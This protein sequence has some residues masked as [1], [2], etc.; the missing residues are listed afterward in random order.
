[1]PAYSG[2]FQ[3]SGESGQPLSQGPCQVR[4]E[5]ESC[6]VTPAGGI[7]VA[8][9]LGDIDS[10]ARSDWDL[11]LKLYTGKTV[12]LRQFGPAFGRMADELTAAWRDRTI[13]CLLLEDL[14]EVARFNGAAAFPPAAASPAEI[15]IY[16]SNIAIL[17]VSAPAAQWRL[18]DVNSLQFDDASY[19][20]TLES[21]GRR[22]VFSK[23]AQKTDEFVSTLSATI[24]ELRQKSAEVLLSTFPF[25][26]PDRLQRLMA[27][28]PEG[29]SVP[30]P[31][32][33]E[34]HPKLADT[35]IARAVGP[36]MK[37]YFDELRSRA[38]ADPLMAGF[39]F[40]RE[41]EEPSEEPAS[42]EPPAEESGDTEKSPLFVWFFFPIAGRNVAAWESTTGSG[43][44][45]YLFRAN[46]PR[47]DAIA[48]LTRGLALVNFRREPVY[49]PDDSLEQQPRFHRYAIGARKLPDLRN[50]RS[51]F[52]GRAI[53]SSLEAWRAQLDAVV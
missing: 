8:F 45:T 29:R 10:L 17:P 48:S 6:I 32:L 35:V 42:E 20:L 34:I 51:A 24:D 38:T 18:A 13:Q 1:M 44:A 30:L 28:M 49:L 25:L 53:H 36:R 37:P 41:D 27:V 52:L 19:T 22:L 12:A 50:L 33:A 4:F 2:K 40:I 46:A 16:K 3:Y 26:D 23:L 14:D 11:Q 7:P 31:A 43:R 5:T 15:R 9:D 47:Q 21:A 39:K